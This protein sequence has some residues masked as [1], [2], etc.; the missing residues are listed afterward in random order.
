MAR[1]KEILV[2]AFCL[3]PL[4]TI[5]IAVPSFAWL[6]H[7]LAEGGGALS[8]VS[9]GL[10]AY[11]LTIAATGFVRLA[12]AVWG[13]VRERPAVR[14]WRG[15]AALRTRIFLYQG[16]AVNLLY[17]AVKLA[18]GLYYRSLWFLFLSAYY[19][20]LA[21]MRFLLFYGAKGTDGDARLKWELRRYRFCG[22]TL[23]FMTLALAG[24][25][26]FMV[27]QNRGYEYP[28]T[29]IY[30]MAA[31]S[32]YAVVSAA[33]SVRRFRRCG[34]P[35]LSAAKAVNLAAAVVSLLSLETAMMTQFGGGD[36]PMFRKI[37]TAATGG[38]VCMF[39]L[40]MALYMILNASKRMRQFEERMK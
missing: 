14:R 21:V 28:G 32:F 33:V 38:G 16:F 20:L 37:M 9:Y 24:I 27:C 25:A 19:I 23:L 35:V 17:S 6:L 22:I 4:P 36:G 29:L 5:L 8:C 2:R 1:I 39:I 7:T 13:R 10:S 34:S 3:P 15:D 11:A 26:A 30:A 18:S 40:G 12:R 31:Y